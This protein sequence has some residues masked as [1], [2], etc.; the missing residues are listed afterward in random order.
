MTLEHFLSTGMIICFCV[1]KYFTTLKQMVSCFTVIKFECE[2]SIEETIWLAYWLSPVI[3][4]PWWKKIDGILQMQ[5][6]K[7]PQRYHMWPI[8]WMNTHTYPT[9][10]WI[11]QIFFPINIWHRQSF[12]EDESHYDL[13]LPSSLPK[14]LLHIHCTLMLLNITWVSIS[15][16]TICMSLTSHASS[17]IS[18]LNIMLEISNSSPLLLSSHILYNV[19][20]C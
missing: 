19:T 18:K 2:W 9:F 11:W 15:S 3:L 5:F 1:I 10:Q 7:I 8:W 20:W 6:T 12:Q 17:M 13:W 4:K 16:K 14:F